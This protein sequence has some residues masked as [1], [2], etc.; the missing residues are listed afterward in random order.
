M[1]YGQLNSSVPWTESLRDLKEIME[2]WGVKDYVMPTYD[3]SKR[4]GVVVFK[5]AINGE[6]EEVP[7]GRWPMEPSKNLRA[8]VLAFDAARK[9]DARGLGHLLRAA[10][11]RFALPSG[12]KTAYELL[13]VPGGTTDKT[14]LRTAFLAAIKRTHPDSGGNEREYEAVIS[15]G[16]AL[17]MTV[18]GANGA[19][20]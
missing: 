19:Q 18:G 3:E 16:R 14:V 2:K 1:A 5:W 12:Q 13:G 7:S 15:A 9:A 11:R 4:N 20:P 10:T 17:G 6:W 8:L